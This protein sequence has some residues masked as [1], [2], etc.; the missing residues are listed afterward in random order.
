M[1]L[2]APARW[3][4]LHWRHRISGTTQW[5]LHRYYHISKPS[6]A[7]ASPSA[8]PP[9]EPKESRNSDK[10]PNRPSFGLNDRSSA[11]DTT[12]KEKKPRRIW[13]RNDKPKKTWAE[14][15]AAKANKEGITRIPPDP[16]NLEL[17]EEG[18][19]DIAQPPNGL[20]DG[21]LPTRSRLEPE[22]V[23][24]PEEAEKKLKV[25]FMGRD[26]FSC[27]VFQQLYAAKGMSITYNSR[28]L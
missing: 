16:L 10:L 5:R 21:Q 25:L 22:Y 3:A 18:E 26:E 15:K 27:L 11:K 19:A 17:D 20:E 2:P 14:R 1:T 24:T 7:S 12:W 13:D 9:W 8:R 23:E 4:C 28:I 6:F